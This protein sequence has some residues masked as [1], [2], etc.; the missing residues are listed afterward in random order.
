MSKTGLRLVNFLVSRDQ[1][2][3]PIEINYKGSGS[4]QTKLGALCT[5]ATQILILVYT[6]NLVIA[7][8][9]NSLQEE[10]T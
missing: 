9:N 4:Y 10:K 3:H 8:R 7:F 5:L 2:G 6:I 1:Y